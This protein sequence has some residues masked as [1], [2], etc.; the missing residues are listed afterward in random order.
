MAGPN[1]FVRSK[2][3]TKKRN[4]AVEDIVWLADQNALRGQYKLARVVNVNM[5]KDGIVKDVNVRT[6]P[7][8]PVSAALTR[9]SR[10]NKIAGNKI[11]IKIPAT[12]LHRDV[13]QLVVLPVEEKEHTQTNR[14][15]HKKT[16]NGTSETQKGKLAQVV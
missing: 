12:V 14:K 9:E 4:V 16:G 15:H 10:T 3:H 2:C 7:S 8:Y 11:S 13:R 1:L 5:D 6:F